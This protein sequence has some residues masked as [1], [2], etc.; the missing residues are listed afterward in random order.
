MKTRT[1]ARGTVH[2]NTQI[3]RWYVWGHQYTQRNLIHN[4]WNSFILKAVSLFLE[5]EVTDKGQDVKGILWN[6]I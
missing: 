3:R 2:K 4:N 6:V 1:Q 5:T